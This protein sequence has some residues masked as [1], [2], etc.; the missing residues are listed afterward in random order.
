MC[1]NNKVRF[2][3][4][5]GESTGYRIIK[6]LVKNKSIHTKAII[7]SSR[8]YDNLIKDICKKKNIPF[9]NK[10][11]FKNKILI[12]KNIAMECDYLF[13]IYSSII[14]PEEILLSL[15][16]YSINLH[17]GSLPYY[18][19]K[20]CVSGAI[21]NNETD[22][23]IT[24]H[25]MTKEIDAGDI[26]FTKRV[27]IN[28]NDTAFSLMEKLKLVSIKS[29][30]EFLKKTNNLTKVKSIKNN[31]KKRKKFPK[32]IPNN[33]LVSAY[34]SFDVLE[35]IYRASYFGPHES[36]W[37]NIKFKYKSKIY[38][39]RKM[40]KIKKI[41]DDYGIKKVDKNS[42]KLNNKRF[43]YILYI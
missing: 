19:G 20:N 22:F 4:T 10:Q 17:P 26:I 5:I 29:V 13:S 43:T 34:M 33:G 32:Y 35:K 16:K 23:G 9:F 40:I 24:I 8:N 39:I 42:Y 7:S 21:Y 1:S 31:I 37:G 15:N 6:E 12:I 25:K 14:I 41:N 30:N 36:P 11:N 18:A 28:K 3:F 2:I 38:K 27:R